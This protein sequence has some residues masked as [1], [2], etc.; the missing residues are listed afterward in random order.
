MSDITLNHLLGQTIVSIAGAEKNNDR[1]VVTLSSGQRV[2]LWHEQD[3]CEGVSIDNV[4]GIPSLLEGFKVVAA[5]EDNETPPYA[6]AREFSA[7]ESHTWTTQKIKTGNGHELVIHW[8][9][10]SN[11]YYS[12]SVSVSLID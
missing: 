9:G 2:Q 6:A 3:C 10:E 8:L 5:S 12:E 1:V 4:V 7:Y 11:G